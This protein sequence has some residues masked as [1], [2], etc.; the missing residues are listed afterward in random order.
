MGVLRPKDLLEDEKVIY[1]LSN[2]QKS[3]PSSF[4]RLILCRLQ[5]LRD[6]ESNKLTRI[7]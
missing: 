4:V 6:K 7:K 3:I 2:L 1:D 5:A